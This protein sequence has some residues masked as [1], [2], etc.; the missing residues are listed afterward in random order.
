MEQTIT[1]INIY[2]KE[3]AKS[4]VDKLFFI[5]QIEVEVIVDF[6]CA[7][8]TMLK[9]IRELRPDIVL[10]GYDSSQEMIDIAKS[11]EE[12]ENHP[13]K[14]IFT[15][16]W[17]DVKNIIQNYKSEG[18]NCALTLSSVIHEVYSYGDSNS[19]TEFWNNVFQSDFDYIVIRDMLTNKRAIHPSSEKD[20]AKIYKT[21]DPHIAEFEALWGSISNYKNLLH[22]LLKYRYNK[23]WF[24]ELRENYMPITLEEMLSK[25]PTNTYSFEYQDHYILPFIARSVKA[26]FGITL[27]EKTHIKLILKKINE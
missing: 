19:I 15:S 1:D 3:M 23:N 18:F 14:P 11:N 6:G 7:D 27:K 16:N 2:R 5:D 24:R 12:W 8:G 22:Y 13:N 17:T 9:F 10:V 25:I 20:V 21:N 26:E 4:M